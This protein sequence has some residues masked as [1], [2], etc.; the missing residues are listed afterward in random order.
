MKSWNSLVN[1]CGLFSHM[2]RFRWEGACAGHWSNPW[3]SKQFGQVA[4][5][6]LCLSILSAKAAESWSLQGWGS[7]VLTPQCRCLRAEQGKGEMPLSAAQQAGRS[8][9]RS[10]EPISWPTAT[11]PGRTLLT[12]ACDSF[13]KDSVGRSSTS[14][15][16]SLKN[17]CRSSILLYLRL[18]N[19]GFFFFF[20]SAVIF[21]IFLNS[22]VPSFL[23]YNW[24]SDIISSHCAWRS[25]PIPALTLFCPWRRRG[26]FTA[27][28]FCLCTRLWPTFPLLAISHSSAA[29]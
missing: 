12:D 19:S 22:L 8:S 1:L 13:G 10:Q 9:T 5:G 26:N 3:L 20:S 24:A 21:L 27:T 4:Q 25:F 29:T 18:S 2:E 11:I 23:S 6:F 7:P 17:C 14:S 15:Q 28:R 16:V